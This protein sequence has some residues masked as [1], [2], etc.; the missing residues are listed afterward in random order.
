M[1]LTTDLDG[2]RSALLDPGQVLDADPGAGSKLGPPQARARRRCWIGIPRSSGRVPS[3][4]GDVAVALSS[5]HVVLGIEAGGRPTKL[6]RHT[7]GRYSACPQAVHVSG[8][9]A[10]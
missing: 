3:E 4:N 2:L 5:C 10:P 1:A 6:W 9:A 7:C 8:P